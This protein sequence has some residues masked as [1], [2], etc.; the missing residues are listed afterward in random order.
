M[1]TAEVK[2]VFRGRR[3]QVTTMYDLNTIVFFFT[4]GPL[5][6]LIDLK[7]RWS[8]WSNQS[9]FETVHA[10]SDSLHSMRSL[11]WREVPTEEPTA[12]LCYSRLIHRAIAWM[13]RTK[14][15]LRKPTWQGLRQL[16]RRAALSDIKRLGSSKSSNRYE[17]SHPF[18][19]A[20]RRQSAY[21]THDGPI[22]ADP[23]VLSSQGGSG[24]FCIYQGILPRSQQRRVK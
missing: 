11:G 12:S 7:T 20:P 2:K 21:H 22:G 9:N 4:G 17:A 16:K 1:T 10:G 13:M 24:A 6:G 5:P 18:R 23:R 19:R 14:Q 8:R 15:H 3:D